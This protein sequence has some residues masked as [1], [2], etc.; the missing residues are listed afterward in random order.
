MSETLNPPEAENAAPPGAGGGKRS[1]YL[2]PLIILTTLFFM[3]GFITSLNDILIPHLRNAFS[4]SYTEAMLIQFCFF[5]AYFVVSI[6]ASF[7]LNAV[8]YQRGIVI[9]LLVAALGCSG[10]YPAASLLSY[11]MFL[12][13][14]FV[15]AAGVTILQV[16]ANPYVTVLGPPETA[17][18]RLTMTQA[19]NSLGTTVAPYLGAILIFSQIGVDDVDQVVAGAAPVSDATT[20]QLP[21]LGLALAFV[22]LGVVFHCLSLPRIATDRNSEA[23]MRP[24]AYLALLRRYP[25]LSLGALAIFLYVG[26][27]VAIGSFLINFLG[28]PAMGGLDESTAANYVAWYWGGA[29]VG[30]FLGAL[31]MRVFRPGRVLGFNASCAALLVVV[32]ILADGPV[33]MYAIIL[34][35]LCNSIMFPTIFSLALTGLG[36][37]RGLGS[38]VLCL[39]IVGGAIVPLLQGVL[40]DTGGLQGSFVIPVLCYL[41]IIFYG[42]RGSTPVD[43]GSRPA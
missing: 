12:G 8:G 4:L 43:A 36:T 39:S 18:S 19:F 9:G 41:Y 10:F 33:A 23:G 11:P 37:Q 17:S 31:V 24:A 2:M 27:E 32:A 16:S 30:R 20:V 25:H 1:A 15:L 22:V 3:W 38:G 7:M 34:V 40:A 21:Y 28:L 26:A 14:L 42:L 29:M 13:A 6:P 5:G 35:G